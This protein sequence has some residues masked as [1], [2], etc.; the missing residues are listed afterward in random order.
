MA[1][2]A[3]VIILSLICLLPGREY[4]LNQQASL[5]TVNKTLDSRDSEDKL[6]N[7]N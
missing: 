3:L 4:H 5:S 7:T 2:F 6:S 1:C